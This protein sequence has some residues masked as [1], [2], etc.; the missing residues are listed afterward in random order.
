MAQRIARVTEPKLAGQS[1]SSVRGVLRIQVKTARTDA[2]SWLDAQKAQVK[3]YW[4]DRKKKFEMAGI[5]QAETVG[6]DQPFSYRELFSRLSDGLAGADPEVRY[7]GGIRF[8]NHRLADPGWKVFGACRFVLPRFELYN[9]NEEITLVCNLIYHRDRPLPL[10]EILSELDDITFPPEKGEWRI[11]AMLGRRDD[12]DEAGWR[13]NVESAIQLLDHGAVQKIVLARKSYF[14][15]NH[16]LNPLAILKRLTL[17]MPECFHF[18]YNPEP[19][20]A[21]IG[22][23]PERLYMRQGTLIQSEAIAGTVPGGPPGRQTKN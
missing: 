2:L 23:T 17:A 10:S 1:G 20:V 14:E 12:P 3:V 19:G 22:A 4:A 9:H 6:F 5:G 18:C 13:Q 21:F 15:F 8:S 7:Y 11:P 16:D